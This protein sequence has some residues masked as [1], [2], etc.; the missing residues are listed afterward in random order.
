M[1]KRQKNPLLVLCQPQ[2]PAVFCLYP[3]N[4]SKKID[5]FSSAITKAGASFFLGGVC[6]W[7][8]SA[9]H[10]SHTR[11][12]RQMTSFLTNPLKHFSS[13]QIPQKQFNLKGQSTPFQQPLCVHTWG[14]D[15]T[16]LLSPCKGLL[17]RSSADKMWQREDAQKNGINQLFK[18]LNGTILLFGKY[19]SSTDT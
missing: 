17:T 12:G 1:Q 4:R 7:S 9:K 18:K 6:V 11:K 10:A 2:M 16:G 5:I 19:H 15:Q 14:R 3:L 8:P 13:L